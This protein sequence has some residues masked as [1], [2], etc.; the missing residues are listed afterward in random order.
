MSDNRH[1]EAPGESRCGTA[2]EHPFMGTIR[3]AVQIAVD[4]ADVHL[5]HRAMRERISNAIGQ[6][7]PRHGSSFV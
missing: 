5:T 7:L 2:S 1:N 3:P 6:A 4:L